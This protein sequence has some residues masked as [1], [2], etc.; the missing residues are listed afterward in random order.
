[1]QPRL[2]ERCTGDPIVRPT[3]GIAARESA[4]RTGAPIHIQGCRTT[5]NR[6]PP[7]DERSHYVQYASVQYAS[8]SKAE[9]TGLFGFLVKRFSRKMLGD[10]PE[11]IGVTWHNRPVLT[12]MMRFGGKAKTWDRL[13]PNLKSFAH[14]AAGDGCLAQRVTRRP[15]RDRW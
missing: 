14:M 3:S 10:V 2:R 7:V 6:R 11:G 15:N 5:L 4:R 1:V 13:D 12:S 9:I 8:D